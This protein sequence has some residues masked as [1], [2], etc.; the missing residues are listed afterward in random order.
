L[1]K[2]DLGKRELPSGLLSTLIQAA[3]ALHNQQVEAANR[4]RTIFVP[5]LAGGFTLLAAAVGAYLK[6]M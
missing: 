3:I 2:D 1:P 6:S 4:W 5:L